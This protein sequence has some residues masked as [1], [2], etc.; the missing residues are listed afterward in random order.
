MLD[1]IKKNIP[2][3]WS[4]K[5]V[6]CRA[7]SILRISN[8]DDEIKESFH[9][10]LRE[11]GSNNFDILVLL[12]NGNRSFTEQKPHYFLNES[13]LLEVNFESINRT[14]PDGRD[15]LM[16]I[17]PIKNIYIE[18]LLENQIIGDA[19][20]KLDQAM[21]MIK[22]YFGVNA[23]KEKYFDHI[24]DLQDGSTNSFIEATHTAPTMIQGVKLDANS[25]NDFKQRSTYLKN[26]S[27]LKIVKDRILR[28]CEI[29]EL[30]SLNA[31]GLKL[32]FYFMAMECILGDLWKGN[33]IVGELA[34]HYQQSEEYVETTLRLDSILDWRA[35]YFHRGEFVNLDQN[36]ERYFHCVILDFMD[37]FLNSGCNQYA[38]EFLKNGLEILFVENVIK[39]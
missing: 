29:V 2:A 15:L 32:A 28:G 24:V 12:G 17:Y 36:S 18:E 31:P 35:R 1:E 25:I 13:D 6:L 14:L 10:C 22:L 9:R 3:E 20:E 19:E 21:G 27:G 30:A 26:Y 7:Y 4:V 16:L 33:Q 34:R 8:H 38:A 37:H 5:Y 23:G 39:K 11:Y